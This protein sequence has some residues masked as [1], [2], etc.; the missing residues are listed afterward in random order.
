MQLKRFETPGIAHYAYLIADGS[1]AA[2][3]DPRRDIDV[4]LDAARAAGVRIRYIVETHRQEDF[5]IGSAALAAATG[6]EVV[7][8]E[9]RLFG[10]GDLRLADGDA[11]ELGG[12]RVTALHT[13]GHT[14]ESMC[15]AVYETGE[16]REPW[17]VLTGDALFY[18]ATGRTDL[19]DPKQ[20]R[21]NAALLYD[22]LHARL[23]PLGD[24][25]LVLPAHG[26]GS[27]CGSGMAE[28][29]WST[30]GEEK[31]SNEVFT[32]DRDTFARR[33][34]SERLPRPPYFRHMEE[35][36][37]AGGLP[38]RRLRSVPLA[39]IDAFADGRQDAL[40]FDTREPEAFAGGHLQGS[41]GIWLEG[42]PV[43]GGW[44]ADAHTPIRLVTDRND[45]VATAALHLSRIGLDNVRAALAGGFGSWRISGRPIE[46]SGVI[47]PRELHEARDRFQVL[48]VREEAEFAAG[49]IPGAHHLYVGDLPTG[50]A[51]L[52]LD[53]AAPLVVT[54]S[55]GHRAGLGVSILLRGRFRDVRNLLGGM[56]A[57]Q[58]LDL[59]VVQRQDPD[60]TTREE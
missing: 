4:Y 11:F 19:A 29:P 57:W 24:S 41:Y 39:E 38:D 40:V 59:P 45:D 52:P 3:V 54:C 35:V 49:H 18:G 32:L 56:T 17:A 43:F 22:S 21:E 53:P 27:V 55:V 46:S 14:P 12:L 34:E 7:N 48:D 2:V 9:H 8:G 16:A 23:G 25:A 30:L 6:A 58:A 51:E 28:R 50:L 26:P 10:H 15:Y 31:R 47:T 1:E 20:T 42:L 36:N 5:V 60:A 33:K 13:P 44:V 37:L